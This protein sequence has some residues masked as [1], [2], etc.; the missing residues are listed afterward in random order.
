MVCQL[1]VLLFFRTAV[2]N[3]EVFDDNGNP[4]IFTTTNQFYTPTVYEVC[5]I[6]Y[7]FFF[8][9]QYVHIEGRIT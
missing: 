3:I 2:L 4:P 5:F 8:G 7:N 6:I 1:L 9:N